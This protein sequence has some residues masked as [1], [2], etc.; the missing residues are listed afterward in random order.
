MSTLRPDDSVRR[1]RSKSPSGRDRDRDRDRS[2]SRSA[3]RS[4]KKESS[5]PKKP[6]SSK[7]SSSADKASKSSRSST[8]S[9]AK[10]EV[11]APNGNSTSSSKRDTYSGSYYAPPP[12][13]PQAQ[14]QPQYAP[15]PPSG[16]P[17]PADNGFTMGGYTD[18]PPEERPGYVPPTRM[19]YPDDA[20]DSSGDEDLAYGDRSTMS[21]VSRNSSYSGS[22]APGYQ[23]KPPAEQTPAAYRYAPQAPPGASSTYSVKPSAPSQPGYQYAKPPDKITYT[24]KPS[25]A[26]RTTASVSSTPHAQFAGQDPST[27]SHNAYSRDARIVDITPGVESR[28]PST[29]SSKSNR[30]SLSLQTP[31]LSQ[32]MDRLSVSGNRPD[33]KGLG[34]GMPPPSPLLEPYH[35][36]YQSLSPMPLAIRTGDSDVESLPP[37]SPIGS[38][39]SSP[40]PSAMRKPGDPKKPKKSVKLYDPE[41]D[42]KKIAAALNHHHRIDTDAICDVLPPL[43][44]ERIMELRKE[45][46]NQVKIQ[47][48]GINLSKHIKMKL[49]GNFGKAAYVTSLGKWESEGYWANFW[50]Q[51]HSA[52]RELLIESLMGRTNRE[53]QEIKR[54]F[55]DKRYADSLVNCMEKELKMDKFRTAVLMVLEERRQEEQDIYPREYVDRDVDILAK[56]LRAPEGGESA[57]LEIIVRRSDAHLKDVLRS[58]EV[59]YGENFARSALKKSNNLVGEVVAHI[60]N[61]VINKPARDAML[62]Y[63]AIRDIGDKNRNEELRYELLVSRLIRIHW[64]RMHLHRV[65][66]TFYEKYGVHIEEAIE[67]ATN[68]DFMIFMCELCQV[69]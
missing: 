46:K 26:P 7:H 40:V 51:S 55:S 30:A 4:S 24:T 3:V 31:G 17:Y 36:T 29:A 38:R 35:G 37:L 2:R 56:C 27:Y 34:G 23:A 69:K 21:R 67:D 11:R 9:S 19:P 57:M 53:V 58:Y 41:E 68:G 32:R 48:K 50:Y 61:G 62:L 13:A 63:H 44:H 5:P 64:D 10:Y 60:L 16:L 6:S 49:T 45:Y 52:R 8:S 20:S 14:P 66:K 12:A 25:N 54:E 42:T 47:G 1:S 39:A 15:P 18:F 22:Y 65:K 33:V 59:V 28:K 43:N